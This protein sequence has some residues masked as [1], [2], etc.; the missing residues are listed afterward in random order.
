[1]VLSQRWAIA[2]VDTRA[3]TVRIRDGGAPNG[4]LAFPE[5]GRFDLPA[6]RAAA[7]AWPG[8]EGMDLAKQVSCTQ[9]YA[10]DETEWAWP[11]GHGRMAAPRRHVRR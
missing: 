1:M 9:S 4:V 7:R 6:L 2:G 5:D 10:W 11:D 3:L 8:L